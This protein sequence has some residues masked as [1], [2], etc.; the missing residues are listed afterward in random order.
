[1]SHTALTALQQIMRALRPYHLRCKNA[2]ELAI[3]ES[4]KTPTMIP[5]FLLA[6]F[7]RLTCVSDYLDD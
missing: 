6:V 7:Y 1:M 5:A 2:L 3:P 4:E